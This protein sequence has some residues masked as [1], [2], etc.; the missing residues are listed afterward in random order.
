MEETSRTGGISHA[1]HVTYMNTTDQQNQ[2]TLIT[3]TKYLIRIHD[4]IYQ[5]FKFRWT[6]EQARAPPS[7]AHATQLP[8]LVSNNE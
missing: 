2:S 6:A 1:I 8:M 7:G 5:E 3:M 4:K